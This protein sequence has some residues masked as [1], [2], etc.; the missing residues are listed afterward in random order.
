M[1]ILDYNH[2]NLENCIHQPKCGWNIKLGGVST[3]ELLKL[4]HFLGE[5]VEVDLTNY[6]SKVATERFF[7]EEKS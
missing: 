7:G 2:C 4:K 6:S 1:N 3:T 5:L